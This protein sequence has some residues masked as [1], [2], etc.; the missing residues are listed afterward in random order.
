MAR[1]PLREGEA[2]DLGRYAGFASPNRELQ[3]RPAPARFERGSK[4]LNRLGL[5]VP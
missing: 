3:D 5:V 4:V 2:D 1:F